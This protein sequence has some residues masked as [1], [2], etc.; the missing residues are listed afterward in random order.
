MKLNEREMNGNR[1]RGL[2][3]VERLKPIIVLIAI[4]FASV[5]AA[6]FGLPK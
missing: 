2:D 3:Q 5:M 1:R 6:A 4:A